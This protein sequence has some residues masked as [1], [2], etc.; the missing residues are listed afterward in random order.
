MIFF[1]R[2]ISRL[3]NANA[4]NLWLLAGLVLVVLPHFAYQPLS[5]MFCCL[6]LLFW[7][8]L[9]EFKRVSLPP[10][11]L[12]I[13]LAFSAFAGVGAIHNTILG[14]HAG[15]ALLLLMLCL[16]LMEMHNKR[17]F[18]VAI[19]LGYF[20]VITS[21]L[22]SQSMLV[23]AY[24][25]LSIIV[26]TTAF[27][28]FNRIHGT[29]NDHSNIKLAA[30]MIVQALP[31]A[32]LLFVLF[33][34]M[35]SPLW[36]LPK[37]A[38]DARSGLSDSM[39][40]G[41]ISN[42]SDDDSV[43]FR[44][45]FEQN[46]PQPSQLYWRGPVFSYFDGRTWSSTDKYIHNKIRLTDELTQERRSLSTPSYRYA[47]TLEPH[48]QHWLFALEMPTQLPS[49]SYLSAK[50]E[51]KANK[52][53]KKLR[54]YEMQ[55]QPEQ[56][57]EPF[58]LRNRHIYL[59]MPSN[60]GIKAQQLMI[61]LIRSFS[62]QK[63]RDKKI[64]QVVLNY[65]SQQP[66]V[67]SKQPPLLLVDPI[68]EFLFD[69][70]KGFCEHYASAFTFLMRAAGIPAR[71]VTGYQGGELNTLGDYVVVRQSDAHAWAEVWLAGNGWT[72]VDPTA[73]LPPERVEHNEH[74]Q[75]FRPTLATT[76]I[77]VSLL[78]KA[79]R[80][81]KFGVDNLNHYW[82]LWVL[83]YNNKRQTSFLAWLGLG[84]IGWQ[85]MTLMLFT[86]LM[87]IIAVVAFRLLYL[88]REH[89]DSAQ[90]A[91]AKYCR[92]LKPFGLVK[93]P[94]EGASHFAERTLSQ[95]PDLREAVTTI[96]QLYNRLRYTKQPPQT[97]LRE[98]R[99]AI[100]NFN[101]PQQ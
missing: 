54:R 94:N 44:V 87:V 82:N 5:I 95:H 8:L 63:D 69:T 58:T 34:R 67:Y 71:V 16:K 50:Y 93:A 14:R 88:T 74:L 4:A 19:C 40:P 78:S 31:L 1:D 38:F 6:V 97:A 25:V 48:D 68:D 59:Q 56:R 22:Y 90:K 86:G 65:F 84:S 66:F 24:M 53:V 15:V 10:R 89:A 21:F 49:N 7:R 33:P 46:T 60:I 23:A 96:T 77:D 13:F 72:R 35:A 61:Q 62:S 98:L 26:L 30:T 91:Y 101:P 28:V 11:W 99:H 76:V 73:V 75:R 51:L 70:R 43:A 100:K 81:V 85:G 36:G 12:R 32:V 80:K 29:L 41:Q 45:D 55:S 3:H 92:K 57:P 2:I 79:W 27:V 39:S 64:V 47:I 9:Y 37:D 17:D 20:V 83:G 42:L 18:A 52:P